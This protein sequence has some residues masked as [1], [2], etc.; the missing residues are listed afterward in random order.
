MVDVLQERDMFTVVDTCCRSQEKAQVEKAIK[1]KL[2]A[3][4]MTVDLE[5]VTSVYVC[6]SRHSSSL[7][8]QSLQLKLLRGFAKFNKKFKKS[9]ITVGVCGWVQVSFGI[10]IFCGKSSQNSSKPI[11]IF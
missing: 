1:G 7:S 11:L 8:P 5:E 6:V 3:I 9:E 10:W 2:K 4:M